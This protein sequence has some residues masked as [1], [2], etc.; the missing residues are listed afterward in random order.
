[1]KRD[2][3][4]ICK[5]GYEY[6]S[7]FFSVGDEYIYLS[8]TYWWTTIRC[9]FFW[10]RHSRVYNAFIKHSWS[11]ISNKNNLNRK[12][13]LEADRFTSC[14]FKY[15]CSHPLLLSIFPPSETVD[16]FIASKVAG[17]FCTFVQRLL[18]ENVKNYQL[19]YSRNK[20]LLLHRVSDRKRIDWSYRVHNKPTGVG[21]Q[22]E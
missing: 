22:L 9:F 21:E 19:I 18:Q 2:R 7:A 11:V 13:G 4:E 10:L 5:W 1:M 20:H 15:S 12:K 6:R 14:P 17:N 3:G 16:Y 8:S